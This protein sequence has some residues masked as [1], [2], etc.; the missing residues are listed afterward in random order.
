ML[1]NSKKLLSLIYNN[2]RYLFTKIVVNKYLF[3]VD[4]KGML[5]FDDNQMGKNSLNLIKDKKFT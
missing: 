4:F 1:A 3:V 2:Q 5:Y